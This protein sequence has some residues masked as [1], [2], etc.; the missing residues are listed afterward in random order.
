MIKHV[1]LVQLN[2]ETTAEQR[3]AIVAA[4]SEL[5]KHVDTIVDFWVG[6]D[7]RL[8]EGN[9]DISVIATFNSEEDFL[10]YSTHAAHMDVVFPVCGP[11]MT[12]YATAQI[13]I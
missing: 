5:P 6:A 8:L 2:P 1:T 4:F 12:G 9:H 11:H 13:A 10:G 7:L 3:A